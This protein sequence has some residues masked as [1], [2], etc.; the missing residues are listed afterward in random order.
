[1]TVTA[2][3][4]LILKLFGVIFI[5]AALLDFATL[6]IPL[7][8]DNQQWQIS[9][10]TGVVDRGVVPMLG[11]ALLTIGYWLDST[12]KHNTPNPKSAT[13][14][15]R[16]PTYILAIVLG[17]IFLLFVP[18]HLINLNQAKVAAV[19]QIEAGAGQ[20]QQQV[21]DF[22]RQLNAFSQNPDVLDEQI[23]EREQVLSTGE[24]NGNPLNQQ[25]LVVLQQETNQLKSLRDLSKD[26]QALKD[27]VAE[28]KANLDAQLQDRQKQAEQQASIQALK[29]GLRI[30]LSS[31]ML[32]IGF[33]VF[34]ALGMRNV[35]AAKQ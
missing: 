21:A 18:I 11:M 35:I 4:T 16:I 6:A 7:Q 2:F 33:A 34:G 10:V 20:G 25:Q 28:I 8:L 31:L 13:V 1:M 14:D 19:R 22:L 17:L 23:A 26:P 12:L 5:L 32:S 24:A 30:G 9:L 15:L 27:K 29:Q 3:T